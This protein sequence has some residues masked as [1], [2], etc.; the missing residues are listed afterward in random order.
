MLLQ[1][2]LILLSSFTLLII[3]NDLNDTLSIFTSCIYGGLASIINSFLIN[4]I[5]KKQEKIKIHNASVGLRIMVVSVVS[6]FILVALLILIGIRIELQPM[7]LL[8]G[9]GVGQFAFIADK[10][11]NKK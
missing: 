6:R 7:A 11:R 10:L 1:I 4:R 5:S 9:F 3:N 8:I 2:V